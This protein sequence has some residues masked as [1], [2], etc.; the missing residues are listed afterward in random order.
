MSLSYYYFFLFSFQKIEGGYIQGLSYFT[1]EKLVFDKSTGQLL[2]NNALNYEV[3]LAKDIPVDFRVHLRYNS[4]NPKGVQGSKGMSLL[5]IVFV[6]NLLYL[7]ISAK[8]F[9]CGPV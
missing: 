5:C 3:Y 2:T 8:Y 1:S 6:T 4:K 7:L 9:F